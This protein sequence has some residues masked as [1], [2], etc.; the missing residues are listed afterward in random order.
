[1][2]ATDPLVFS[3]LCEMLRATLHFLLLMGGVAIAL[4]LIDRLI[5]LFRRSK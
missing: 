2:H 5:G 3:I 1:L 4:I